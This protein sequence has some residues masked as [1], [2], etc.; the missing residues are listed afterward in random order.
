MSEAI[1]V[2]ALAFAGTLIGSL[3]ANHRGYAVLEQRVK[4]LES[5]IDRLDQTQELM[6]I[7]ERLTALETRTK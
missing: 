6:R 1:V 5:K 2:A 7:R 4:E 3:L